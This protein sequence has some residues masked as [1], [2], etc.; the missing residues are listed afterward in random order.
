MFKTRVMIA[1]LVV[2]SV[3]AAG[4]FTVSGAGPGTNVRDSRSADK[5][6][7]NRAVEIASF[8]AQA[9][10]QQFRTLS[11]S[12]AR[13]GH[14]ATALT[15]GRVLI[16]GGENNDGP[17]AEVELIDTAS[18]ASSSIAKLA[19]GR[20]D[21]TATMLADGKIL[22]IGGSN[23]SQALRSTEIFDPQTESVGGGPQL[24]RSRSGHTAT[25]LNDGRVLVVGGRKDQSAEV[26][27]PESGRF[28]LLSSKS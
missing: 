22:I 10:G 1:I 19:V 20:T 21:H 8:N 2:L 15:N 9:R 23:G 17:V 27:E 13:H 25:L 14:T 11:L 16:A 24:N 26:F 6:S 5:Q 12:V 28:S 18:Q 7:V 4:S 3:T